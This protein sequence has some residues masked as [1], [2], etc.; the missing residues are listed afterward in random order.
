MKKLKIIAHIFNEGIVEDVGLIA[1]TKGH[2]A[3]VG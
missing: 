3:I 2:Y 1:L